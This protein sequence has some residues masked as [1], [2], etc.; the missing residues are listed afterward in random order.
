MC[1]LLQH[2]C[3]SLWWLDIV[4]ERR[5]REK[6]YIFMAVGWSRSLFHHSPTLKNDLTSLAFFFSFTQTCAQSSKQSTT[7]STPSFPPKKERE[8]EGRCW[9]LKILCRAIKEKETERKKKPIFQI[10]WIYH[11]ELTQ[12]LMWTTS[13]QNLLQLWQDWVICER[14]CAMLPT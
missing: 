8:T 12:I 7:D 3:C 14:A 10:N 1:V 9:Q 2:Q 5:G 11:V 4:H 13:H 6:I